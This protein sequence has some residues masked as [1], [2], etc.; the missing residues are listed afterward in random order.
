MIKESRSSCCLTSSIVGA[1]WASN[2][3]TD[4]RHP[5]PPQ[6]ARA[7]P[8]AKTYGTVSPVLPCG[9]QPA[10]GAALWTDLLHPSP[11]GQ[12]C[13]CSRSRGRPRCARSAPVSFS[14]AKLTAQY[15]TPAARPADEALHLVRRRLEVDRLLRDRNGLVLADA[16]LL[17]RR[18]SSS[19]T[20]AT[21]RTARSAAIRNTSRSRRSRLGRPRRYARV[22]LVPSVDRVGPEEQVADEVGQEDEQEP[23][24]PPEV[25]RPPAREARRRSGT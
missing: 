11:T 4:E 9:R 21:K 16:V 8:R 14:F 10:L 17:A 19:T 20:N 7:G 25:V 18:S 23:P 5:R 12:R 3:K 6:A 13:R 2:D 24:E 22:E 15:G 1:S